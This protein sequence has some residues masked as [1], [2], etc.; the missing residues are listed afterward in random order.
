MNEFSLLP[1]IGQRRQGVA[2]M[3]TEVKMNAFAKW[4]GLLTDS[5]VTMDADEIQDRKLISIG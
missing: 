3:Y 4:Y 5:E 2:V 1:S